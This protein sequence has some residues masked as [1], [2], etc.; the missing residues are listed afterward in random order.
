[1]FQGHHGAALLISGALGNALPLPVLFLL[2]QLQ[3]IIF[4]YLAY[5][6]GIEKVAFQE[7]RTNAVNPFDLLYFPYS[8]GLFASAV[9]TLLAAVVFRGRAGRLSAAA[10]VAS[11]WLLDLMVHEPDLDVCFPFRECAKVGLGLWRFLWGS[12]VTESGI[13]VIGAAAFV[14]GI[15]DKSV[16][17]RVGLRLAPLVCFM[18]LFTVGL[19]FAPP[20]PKLDSSITVQVYVSYGLTAI[21]AW[22]IE[23]PLRVA[24]KRD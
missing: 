24:V 2:S 9:Y 18:V 22:A 10:C 19:P 5:V 6:L 17:R 12:V 14:G 1:M 16:K 13:V 15:K 4:V 7:P 8:H 11:H 23:R 20:P 3:D 21:A